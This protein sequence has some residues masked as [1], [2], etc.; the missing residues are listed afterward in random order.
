MIGNYIES[1]PSDPDDVILEEFNINLYKYIPNE[2]QMNL[3]TLFIKFP[4]ED[5]QNQMKAI[6]T[7]PTEDQN[8]IYPKLFAYYF[9][10]LYIE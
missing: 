5:I 6:L 3:M 9:G 4:Q 2:D 1:D 7:F 8:Y 10:K